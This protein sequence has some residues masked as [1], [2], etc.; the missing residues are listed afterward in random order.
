MARLVPVS[1]HTDVPVEHDVVPE[2]HWLVG[3]HE[4]PAVH[5]VHVPLLH[6]WLVPQVVPLATDVPVSVQ[7]GKPV[8]QLTVPVWHTLVGVHAAPAEHAE[9]V[10][11]S[12]TRLVPQAVP[13]DTDVP[14]SVHTATPVVHTTLPV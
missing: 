8:A 10:P 5:A 4:A 3:V 9:H 6:T 14:V 12:Q 11:L 2:W 1:V 13:L 7:T